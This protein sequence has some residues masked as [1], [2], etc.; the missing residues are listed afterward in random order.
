MNIYLTLLWNADTSEK[1]WEHETCFNAFLK[2]SAQTSNHTSVKNT[3]HHAASLSPL[4]CLC[5]HTCK[6][7]TWVR[8]AWQLL[9]MQGCAGMASGP[10]RPRHQATRPTAPRSSAAAGSAW[11][12]APAAAPHGLRI[13]T[14]MKLAPAER[15]RE[16]N[17][18]FKILVF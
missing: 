8:R 6:T 16:K 12:P 5:H 18:Y 14:P 17:M 9:E 11:S 10:G 15:Y 2:L 1:I 7:T 13:C 3:S 4:S